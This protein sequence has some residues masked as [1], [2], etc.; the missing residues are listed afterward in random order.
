MARDAKG[1]AAC[2]SHLLLLERQGTVEGED[3]EA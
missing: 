1:C 2:D 3:V